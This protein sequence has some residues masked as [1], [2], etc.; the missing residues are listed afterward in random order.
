[1]TNED[2]HSATLTNQNYGGIG[3]TWDEATF[4]W[5]EGGGTWENPY[6]LKN[7]DIHTGILTNQDKT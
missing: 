4:T 1:M 2:K 7:Q 6:G 5:N 3:V